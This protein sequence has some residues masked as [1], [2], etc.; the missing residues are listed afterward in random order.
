MEKRNAQLRGAIYGLAVGDALGVP[1]EFMERGT[2]RIEG[3]QGYG[4]Y[5]QPEGTWG[6]GF[7]DFKANG[8]GSLMRILP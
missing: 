6:Y 8:N 4:T 3:M 7:V 2:F 5:R 1:V